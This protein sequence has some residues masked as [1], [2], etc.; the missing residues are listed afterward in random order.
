MSCSS[1]CLIVLMLW[2]RAKLLLNDASKLY[3]PNITHGFYGPMR[4]NTNIFQLISFLSTL[5][6]FPCQLRPCCRCNS[7][8]PSGSYATKIQQPL[9]ILAVALLN[10]YSP[11]LQLAMSDSTHKLQLAMSDSTHKY[12]CIQP[13]HSHKLVLV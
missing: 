11:W 9:Q 4:V 7:V 13:Q 6:K 5:S 12:K 8:L 1:F 2:Q 3:F 10:Y